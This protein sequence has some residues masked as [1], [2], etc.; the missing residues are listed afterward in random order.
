M[1]IINL[2]NKRHT[3]PPANPIA[4]NRKT[5]EW[6]PIFRRTIERATRL[7]MS[8]KARLRLILKVYSQE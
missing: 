3:R 5:G 8:R 1:D 7:P 6:Y 4:G 2:N